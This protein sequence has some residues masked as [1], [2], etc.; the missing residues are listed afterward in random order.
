M[1][2]VGINT[3][4]FHG[5]ILREAFKRSGFKVRST[6]ARWPRAKRGSSFTRREGG[7]KNL[8][9]TVQ[10]HTPCQA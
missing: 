7:V 8:H 6:R 1:Q 9:F 2:L 4:D 3:Q 10:E 5:G